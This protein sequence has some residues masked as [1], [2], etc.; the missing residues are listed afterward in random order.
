MK[1]ISNA[2]TTIGIISFSFQ[3]TYHLNYLKSSSETKEEINSNFGALVSSIAALSNVIHILETQPR[4]PMVPLPAELET[5]TQ[6]CV[7]GLSEV[8]AL[9]RLQQVKSE[10]LIRSKMELKQEDIEK[11]QGILQTQIG[12]LKPYTSSYS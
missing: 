6:E 10:S 1:N 11:I 2:A 3:F 5:S 4:N 8:E 12:V 7:S 9:L